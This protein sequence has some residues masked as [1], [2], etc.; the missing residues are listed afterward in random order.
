MIH[1]LDVTYAEFKKM[2]T[3]SDF[4][5]YV[6]DQRFRNN[7]TKDSK[8]SSDSS[9]VV[10]PVKIDQEYPKSRNKANI[11]ILPLSIEDK[12]LTTGTASVM[13]EF[14]K[15][16]DIIIRKSDDLLMYNTQNRKLDIQG[17]RECYIFYKEWIILQK[18]WKNFDEN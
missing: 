9:Y 4:D 17:A 8:G 14:A 3:G 7:I 16:L 1:E 18:T 5:K 10:E 12:S 13:R 15:D 11:M 2:S 6:K